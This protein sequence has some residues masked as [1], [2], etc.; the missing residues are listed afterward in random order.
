MRAVNVQWR[1]QVGQHVGK[2]QRPR[3]Q[4]HA[5][6]MPDAFHAR[7]QLD[8][9]GVQHFIADHHA[10]HRIWQCLHPAHA[11]A[12]GRQPRLLPLAQAAR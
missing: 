2:H 8:R 6:L 5:A 1:P 10:R 9:H 3:V 11:L 4:R 12:I 7:Q